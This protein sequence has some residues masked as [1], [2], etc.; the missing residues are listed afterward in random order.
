MHLLPVRCFLMEGTWVE[1]FPGPT[2][3]QAHCQWGRAVEPR[4]QLLNP[5]VPLVV[6]PYLLSKRI[7]KLVG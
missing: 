6:R 3:G 7:G 2:R 5:R 1:G 4:C